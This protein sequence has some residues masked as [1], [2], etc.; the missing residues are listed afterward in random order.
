MVVRFSKK[1]KIFAKKYFPNRLIRRFHALTINKFL[2][3][4]HNY[5][6][7]MI[8]TVCFYFWLCYSWHRNGRLVH[9]ACQTDLG[10]N[11]LTVQPKRIEAAS[12]KLKSYEILKEDR[13]LLNSHNKR[14]NCV[15]KKSTERL[16]SRHN[17]KDTVVN[18]IVSSC[19]L[20]H[21]IRIYGSANNYCENIHEN[22]D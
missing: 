8:V 7:V 20:L 6:V 10:S 4:N 9:V 2:Y 11:D 15:Y 22:P 13:T 5:S 21:E 3:H 12:S 16:Q 19:D 14:I 18:L 17:M 1:L